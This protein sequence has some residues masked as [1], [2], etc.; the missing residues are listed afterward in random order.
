MTPHLSL[1][2][3]LCVPG[4]C[5]TAVPTTLGVSDGRNIWLKLRRV[6]ASFETLMATNWTIAAR[7]DQAQC[8]VS[9]S[10][11]RG[12]AHD[13]IGLI[14]A[15]QL[16]R[17]AIGVGV[18]SP[19][20]SGLDGRPPNHVAHQRTPRPCFKILSQ[21]LSFAFPSIL[22]RIMKMQRSPQDI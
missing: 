17:S 5:T 11:E 12:A 1:H 16:E 13:L 10:L 21:R 3:K 19:F 8:H 20:R 9:G 4:R 18:R 15:D 2:P 22:K 6:F 14:S 7:F